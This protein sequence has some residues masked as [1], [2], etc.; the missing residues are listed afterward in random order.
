MAVSYISPTFI[1]N[2]FPVHQ[3]A[4]YPCIVEGE[5]VG[6]WLLAQLLLFPITNHAVV[7]YWHCQ[8]IGFTK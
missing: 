3:I 1:D 2:S 6:G 8:I 4:S 5:R 7:L